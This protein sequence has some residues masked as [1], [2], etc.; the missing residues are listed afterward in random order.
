[1]F[2]RVRY[3]H[4]YKLFITSMDA[5]TIDMIGN[6]DSVEKSMPIAF[7]GEEKFTAVDPD[8]FFI[9]HILSGTAILLVNSEKYYLGAGV[10]LF[11]PY[12]TKIRLLASYHLKAK[13]VSFSGE[14]LSAG[15]NAGPGIDE[16][17]TYFDLFFKR[18]MLYNGVL[19]LN[20]EL[21]DRMDTLL[22]EIG[23][24]VSYRKGNKWVCNVRCRIFALLEIAGQFR[25]TF[26]VSDEGRRSVG[27]KVLDYIHLNLCKQITIRELCDSFQTNHTTI[28]QKFRQLTGYSIIEYII[29]KRLSLACDALLYTELSVQEISEK[30]GFRDVSYF[31]RVF[32]KRM[33]ETPL[34]YRK[35]H[36]LMR[37]E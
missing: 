16:N 9:C 20:Q 23:S 10:L 14:F 4:Y 31:I 26:M 33:N 30:Y 1:M 34:Q 17:T 3:N 8:R 11:F 13:S 35:K 18:N 22:D 28:S 27:E 24:E 15:R 2:L 36:V 32:R 21:N 37:K 7:Y 25:K 6:V 5:G 19:P 29:D 12:G